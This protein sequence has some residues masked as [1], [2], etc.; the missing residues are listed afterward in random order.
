MVANNGFLCKTEIVRI[1]MVA[2]LITEAL[3]EQFLISTAV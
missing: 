2:T 3:F 1:F